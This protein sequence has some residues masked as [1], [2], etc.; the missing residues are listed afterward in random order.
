M[1]AEGVEAMG[2]SWKGERVWIFPP[3]A[4]VGRA[5]AHARRSGAEGVMV[6]PFWEAQPWWPVL[7]EAAKA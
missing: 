4:A 1:G 6:V 3:F 2:I 7:M 5:V